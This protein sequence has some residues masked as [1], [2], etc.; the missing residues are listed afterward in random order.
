[1]KN[2]QLNCTQNYPVNSL[3]D[4]ILR[5]GTFDIQTAM[6]ESTFHIQNLSPQ[7][8]S[9]CLPVMY[10]LLLG[11]WSI[12]NSGWLSLN[13]THTYYVCYFTQLLMCMTS[14]S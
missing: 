1:M 7:D 9:R 3:C 8:I 4:I 2:V 14:V 10:G 12:L 6:H 13:P 11:H 5:F